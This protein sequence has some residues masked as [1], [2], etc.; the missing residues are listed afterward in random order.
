MSSTSGSCSYESIRPTDN[1]RLSS[2]LLPLGVVVV[3]EL[4]LAIVTLWAAAAPRRNDRRLAA[5]DVI[6]T[7]SRNPPSARPLTGH[8]VSVNRNRIAGFSAAP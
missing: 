8:A 4:W 6:W 2:G 3:L 5:F 1:E 7:R